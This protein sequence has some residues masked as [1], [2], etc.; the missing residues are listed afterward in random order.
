[1]NKFKEINKDLVVDVMI[2]EKDALLFSNK[3]NLGIPGNAFVYQN[4]KTNQDSLEEFMKTRDFLRK[5]FLEERDKLAPLLFDPNMSLEFI[6]YGDTE[7]VYVLNA[8]GKLWS[9]L[10]KQPGIDY[11]VVKKEYDNLNNLAIDNPE[12]IV[13]P[14]YYYS[15]LEN[16]LYIA[17]YIYQARC[18][19]SQEHE[20]GIYVPEPFYR[21]DTFNK[22]DRTTVN[23]CMIANLIRLYDEER[24]LGLG[25]CKIGGGDFILEKSWDDSS[26]SI[27]VTL[28]KMKL[29][30]AREMI[31]TN[32]EKY[33][34]LLL[35]EFSKRTYYKKIDDRDPS[36]LVNHKNRIPMTLDEIKSG[37]SLGRKLRK[38]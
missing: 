38:K 13:K 1:M 3:E 25:A 5:V 31:S 24:K 7:Q 27:D 19:A 29:I 36:I 10:V 23:I 30:A 12:I 17:P 37:I 35:N 21:F 18:I 16:E 4:L 8:N 28:E 32:L 11:G 15:D 2:E 6:N 26:K 34:E 14:E 33:E 22:E 9:V 20:Y